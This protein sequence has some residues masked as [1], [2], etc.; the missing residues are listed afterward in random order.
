MTH[1]TSIQ[2]SHQSPAEYAIHWTGQTTDVAVVNDLNEASVGAWI[3]DTVQQ[4]H[5][6][7]LDG[8]RAWAITNTLAAL[9][10]LGRSIE[11]RHA[12]RSGI[13]EW[14]C[15]PDGLARLLATYACQG[16]VVVA[17]VYGKQR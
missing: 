17:R 2:S 16:K 13:A 1:P 3:D 4:S 6:D 8:G 10:N 5:L 11:S 12:T 15:T 9:N 14:I 7:K